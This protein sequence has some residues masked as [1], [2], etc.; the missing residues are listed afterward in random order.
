MILSIALQGN[1]E[2][3]LATRTLKLWLLGLQQLGRMADA[4]NKSY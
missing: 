1:E 2:T 4:P 3:A